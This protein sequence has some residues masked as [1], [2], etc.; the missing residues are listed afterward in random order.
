MLTSE[1]LTLQFHPGSPIY[2]CVGVEEWQFLVD[3]RCESSPLL[4]V[5]C[6]RLVSFFPVD[7]VVVATMLLEECPVEILGEAGHNSLLFDHGFL[8]QR[9]TAVVKD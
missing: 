1:E 9:A 2:D 7:I 5:M 6:D 3:E 8:I 4:L